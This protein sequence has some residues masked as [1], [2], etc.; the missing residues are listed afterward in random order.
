[1]IKKI[2]LG[3][4]WEHIGERSLVNGE[5]GEKM[6]DGIQIMMTALSGFTNDQ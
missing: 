6:G 1:M 4:S 5:R 2:F 3:K